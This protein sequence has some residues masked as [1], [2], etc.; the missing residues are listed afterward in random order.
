MKVS[1]LVNV[2]LVLA[3]AAVIVLS[4]KKDEEEPEQKPTI[5][6]TSPPSASVEMETG[7]TLA[8]SFTASSNASSG[9]DLVVFRLTSKFENEPTDT[10]ENDSISGST[11]SLSNYKV[12]VS[13]MPGEQVFKIIIKDKAGEAASKSITVDI[14]EQ[15]ANPPTISFKTGGNFISDDVTLD[16]NTPIEFGVTAQSNATTQ[17]ELTTFTLRRKYEATPA[18]TVFDTSFTSTTF[19]WEGSSVAHPNQGNEIWTFRVEDAEGKYGVVSFTIS[20]EPTVSLAI[21]EGIVLGSTSG[22]VAQGVNLNTGET[23]ILEDLTDPEDQKK[24]QL[25]YFETIAHGHTLVAPA[26]L[27]ASNAYPTSIGSWN[28]DNRK[29][30]FISKKPTISENDFDIIEELQQLTIIIFQN[31][32]VGQAQFCS[33][34]QSPPEGF[35]VGDIL[36][37]ETQGGD[38]GLIRITEV[39]EGATPPESTIKFDLKIEIS[40]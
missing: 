11:F 7:D 36:A 6:L 33:E 15:N 20:T 23:Y 10:L 35:E 9:S 38:Q 4:C 5:N 1:N 22:D 3:M 26:W 25:A 24:V 12:A 34:V 19:E 2:I 16:V 37:V 17:A 32:G 21:H 30:T 18:T 39:N 40:K 8:I 13:D 29:V 31:G 28:E 14:S 27:L